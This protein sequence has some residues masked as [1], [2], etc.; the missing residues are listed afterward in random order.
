[1][2]YINQLWSTTIIHHRIAFVV[3]VFGAELLTLWIN[4]VPVLAVS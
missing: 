3:H 4:R 1:M 2:S